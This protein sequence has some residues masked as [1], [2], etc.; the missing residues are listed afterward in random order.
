MTILAGLRAPVDHF[1]DT[2]LV[3]DPD[4][5]LR[6]NRLRLLSG[7]RSAFRRIADIDAIE[8]GA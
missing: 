8:E 7:I 1:F 6:G 4:P 3:N 5:A 2:V